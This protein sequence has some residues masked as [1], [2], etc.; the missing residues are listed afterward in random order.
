VNHCLVS[1]GRLRPAAD[2][3]RHLLV[4][5]SDEPRPPVYP[6]RHRARYKA[7][8]CGRS[9]YR[10][11]IAH[12]H[13]TDAMGERLHLSCCLA[14]KVQ[15]NPDFAVTALSWGCEHPTSSR[16]IGGQ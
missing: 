6:R 11:L 7:I 2:T 8:S 13:C 15:G 4:R 1:E 10:P 14:R 3:G 9:L 5:G 12:R 16:R